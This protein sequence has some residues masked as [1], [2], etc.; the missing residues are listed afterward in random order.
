[1]HIT[2]LKDKGPQGD[3]KKIEECTPTCLHEAL[4][5]DHQ[6]SADLPLYLCVLA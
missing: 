2:D 4:S 3:Q 6:A 1:M 5:R